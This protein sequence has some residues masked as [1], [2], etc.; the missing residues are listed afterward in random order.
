MKAMTNKSFWSLPWWIHRLVKMLTGQ[1]LVRKA[2]MVGDKTLGFEWIS[3]AEYKER[4]N[5][6]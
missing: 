6:K 5:V 2:A 4:F 1:V 3:A